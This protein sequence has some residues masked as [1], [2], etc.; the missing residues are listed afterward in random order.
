MSQRSIRLLFS[1]TISILHTSVFVEIASSHSARESGGF[2]EVSADTTTLPCQITVTPVLTAPP[3]GP[4]AL[5]PAAP[6]PLA[7]LKVLPELRV[8]LL[9]TLGPL[10]TPVLMPPKPTPSPKLD[11]VTRIF[12]VNERPTEAPLGAVFA[13]GEGG[14]WQAPAGNH[15]YVPPSTYKLLPADAVNKIAGAL[16]VYVPGDALIGK[17]N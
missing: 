17:D 2:L 15:T 13:K 1:W 4:P 11:G 3:P 8:D 6:P 14:E 7:P 12:D 5:V 16:P 10:P 9:P